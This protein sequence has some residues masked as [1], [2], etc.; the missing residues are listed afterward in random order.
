MKFKR[1]LKAAVLSTGLFLFTPIIAD[2]ASHTVTKGDTLYSIANKYNTTVSKLKSEN[3]LKTNTINI[4]QT[5]KVKNASSKSS[6]KTTA[7]ASSKKVTQSVV[8][9]SS[10][11][12]YRMIATAFTANCRGCSGVTATGFNLKKNPAAKV[13]AVDPK[14]IPLGS[15]VHVEGYGTAVAADTGGRIKGHKID[16]FYSTKN[17]AY[18][19][20]RRAVTV[21]VY[22]S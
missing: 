6:S 9:N 14:V 10:Y 21:K 2:A 11:K 5:I 18:N 1:L 7:K 8:K 3:N 12:T 22:E 15:K 17:S 20:G 19:W 16:V 13:I 4:G